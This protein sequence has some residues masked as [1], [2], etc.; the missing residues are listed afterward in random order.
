MTKV[1]TAMTATL[2]PTSADDDSPP[3]TGRGSG[4]DRVGQATGLCPH[5]LSCWTR[6][7]LLV[8]QDAARAAK[9]GL[10]LLGRVHFAV[11]GGDVVIELGGE[12]GRV[13]HAAA[14][15]DLHPQVANRVTRGFAMQMSVAQSMAI[16]HSALKFLAAFPVLR[17]PSLS[18]KT[19]LS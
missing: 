16:F 6:S 13:V 17:K 14:L 3:T 12:G 7:G 2:T 15:G 18:M 9:V 4:A 8:A 10:D 19:F 1:P 5:L 11:L